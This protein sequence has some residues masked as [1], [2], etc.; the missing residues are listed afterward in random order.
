[1][2]IH[3]ECFQCGQ[4]ADL[5]KQGFSLRSISDEVGRSKAVIWNFLNEGNRSSQMKEKKI[6]MLASSM[7]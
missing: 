4:V 3:I 2:S 7:L 1:M 6:H 5:H